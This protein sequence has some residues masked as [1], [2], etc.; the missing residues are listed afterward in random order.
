[1]K[2]L[3]FMLAILALISSCQKEAIEEVVAVENLDNEITSSKILAENPPWIY[4]LD[5]RYSRTCSTGPGVC[6][7]NEEGEIWNFVYKT[8]EG[9][10]PKE[11]RDDHEDPDIGGIYLTLE[12]DKVH[13]VFTEKV[14]TDVLVIEEDVRL[15]REL[16]KEYVEDGV[17]IK[18]G[19]YKISYDRYEK[20]GEAWVSYNV[21]LQEIFNCDVFLSHRAQNG[22]L[23]TPADVL[24]FK[25]KLHPF[26]YNWVVNNNS[27]SSLYVRPIGGGQITRHEF[28]QGLGNNEVLYSNGLPTYITVG[29]QAFMD[30]EMMF[31]AGHVQSPF[32]ANQDGYLSN[33]TST[34]LDDFFSG[35]CN[36]RD[37]I[38]H[39]IQPCNVD[40]RLINRAENGMLVTPADELEF[41]VTS[42]TPVNNA[43]CTFLYAKFPGS[44][45][46]RAYPLKSVSGNV[47]KFGNGLPTMTFPGG[48]APLNYQMVIKEFGNSNVYCNSPQSYYN[49]YSSAV[50]D[51]IFGTEGCQH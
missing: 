28:V 35:G 29:G 44:T 32:C 41:T 42:Q 13:F 50:L 4:V 38:T 14:E 45:V 33:F 21:P 43:N 20:Y 26:W 18:A 15:P 17:V 25:V 7:K 19:E 47:L 9:D 23:I 2:K 10:L 8:I 39:N 34:Q 22:M 51:A 37:E 6:F 3:F 48:G 12:G 5:A 16:F 1:M 49:N 11:I 46:V 24:N 36:H 40:V 31:E 30:Y 27:C